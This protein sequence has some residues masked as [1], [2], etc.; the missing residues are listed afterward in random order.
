MISKLNPY[1]LFIY[2]YGYGYGYT[3]YYIINYLYFRFLIFTILYLYIS[4]FF[5]LVDTSI[6]LNNIINM[7]N[8]YNIQTSL[9]I[10]PLGLYLDDHWTSDDLNRSVD[11]YSINTN[12]PI[13]TKDKPLILRVFRFL[14][15]NNL[16]SFKKKFQPFN[17][18]SILNSNQS[19]SIIDIETNE[20]YLNSQYKSN[21]VPTHECVLVSQNSE[22]NITNYIL[23]DSRLTKFSQNIV[24]KDSICSSRSPSISPVSTCSIISPVSN[25]VNSDNQELIKLINK[26]SYY[27]FSSYKNTPFVF[28]V[29]IPVNPNITTEAS[30]YSDT[31][32]EDYTRDFNMLELIKQTDSIISKYKQGGQ[33]PGNKDTWMLDQLAALLQPELDLEGE[34]LD[35]IK[36]KLPVVLDY[37]NNFLT[38]KDKSIRLTELSNLILDNNNR[39]NMGGADIDILRN[40]FKAQEDSNSNNEFFRYLKV[41]VV[42]ED[43]QK[44]EIKKLES[45]EYYS[46]K[47]LNIIIEHY[48]TTITEL[49]TGL[50][51]LTS[52]M[53]REF[54]LLKNAYNCV[55]SNN[56][57]VKDKSY[58]DTWQVRQIILE[59]LIDSAV[60]G[61][62]KYYILDYSNKKIYEAELHEN[63]AY[64]SVFI[65]KCN[66]L[67][68]NF[69]NIT[70][71][72]EYDARIEEIGSLLETK[73]EQYDWIRYGEAVTKQ[74]H[75]NKFDFYSSEL[76]LNYYK[77]HYLASIPLPKEI[78]NIIINKYNMEDYSNKQLIKYSTS[79][80]WPKAETRAFPYIGLKHE[81]EDIVNKPF[82]IPHYYGIQI[83][84]G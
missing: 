46:P 31:L 58:Y 78:R 70:T 82:N 53:M 14:D 17:L 69:N 59:N 80:K 37:D 45:S 71:I 15:I 43:I 56:Y 42:T 32:M 72:E 64:I 44:E 12:P 48:P 54:W 84:K 2:I 6:L 63:L 8:C 24:I 77:E 7:D 50:I 30:N 74:F 23:G 41:G 57:S 76:L 66:I 19:E 36:E 67:I 5:S 3:S 20:K 40:H 25:N 73:S 75:K 52:T 18:P 11:T 47:M 27:Y 9:N 68:D 81:N 26:L 38:I 22:K 34:F 33:L 10:K 29:N 4:L 39:V 16:C 61:R 35:G 51:N 62:G 65:F 1:K 83:K 13:N 55:I 60:K 49:K 79:F 21:I 28:I